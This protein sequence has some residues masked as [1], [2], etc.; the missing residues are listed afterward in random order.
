[1]TAF[2]LQCHS[3]YSD[4]K[5][6]PAEVMQRAADDGMELV[7]L[8]DHDTI[9]GVAEARQVAERLGLR[10]SNGTE[11]S[12]VEGPHSDLHVCGYELDITD[13]TLIDA[14]EDFRADRQARVEGIADRLEELGFTVDRTVLKERKAA[15]QPI[16]RPHIA[17]AVLNHPANKERLES[18][19]I[20]DKNT[21]FPEYIVPGAK[22]FVQRTRPT[23]A[24]A[25]D[26]IHGAGGVAI[27]AHPF[28]DLD[29]ADEV[30]ATIERFQGYGVDGIEVFYPTH[31][32]EH[33]RILFETC[34]RLGLLKTGSSD[35]HAPDHA[36]FN[37]FGIFER[38]GYEPDLG[39]I[40]ARSARV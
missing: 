3:S 1:M 34:E 30:V 29:D 21:F 39:P 33:T 8:T 7:A 38:Y 11:L 13:S 19:G 24:E 31:S 6:P 25:I 10:F 40:G 37:T 17:D 32:E 27:W 2:D 14:L 4:G 28:W 35:F 22:A 9:E 12:S 36:R 16:G 23:V 15:G 20:T 26:V 5:L 18:E